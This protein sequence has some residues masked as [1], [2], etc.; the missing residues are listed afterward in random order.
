M[1]GA[2]QYRSMPQVPREFGELDRTYVNVREMPFS[3][4]EQAFDRLRKIHE[5]HF[6]DTPFAYLHLLRGIES[7]LLVLSVEKRQAISRCLEFLRRRLDLEYSRG[8]IHGKAAEATIVA[9][10][11]ME[12]GEID[13]ARTLLEEE[14]RQLEELAEVCRD[15]QET[16]TQ[17]IDEL[18]L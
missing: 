2:F 15:C 7:R 1:A 12:C 13:L 18:D 10:Y 4:A 5:E 6:A 17:C 9:R 16:V 14:R 11:A 8:E 3:E